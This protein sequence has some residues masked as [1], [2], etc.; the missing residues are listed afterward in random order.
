MQ[1]KN[2]RPRSSPNIK[3]FQE[4]RGREFLFFVQK[5]KPFVQIF[6]EYHRV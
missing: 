2:S 6:L 3:K 4:K 1:N 5:I